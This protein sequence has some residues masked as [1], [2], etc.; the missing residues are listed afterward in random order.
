MDEWG[1]NF[2]WTILNTSFNGA[3]Q[4]C[5]AETKNGNSKKQ[6]FGSDVPKSE[7]AF[8]YGIGPN[9]VPYEKLLRVTTY[10]EIQEGEFEEIE[11]AETGEIAVRELADQAAD[12]REEILSDKADEGRMQGGSK[13][14]LRGLRNREEEPDDGRRSD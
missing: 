3:T 4:T 12:R 8:I 14:T 7:K 10:T 5:K 2:L 13:E 1:F 6:E 9:F 11:D